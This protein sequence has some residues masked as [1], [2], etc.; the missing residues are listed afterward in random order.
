MQKHGLYPLML[1]PSLHI[2]V[3]G[4]KRLKT[5]L[6]KRVPSDEP[7]G[8]SWELHD[9]TIVGNGPLAGKTLGELVSE[10]GVLLLGDSIN[11]TSG[12]PLLAK[13]IDADSWLSV[14]VHPN[15]EQARE[16]EG[17]PRGKS[18]AWIVIHAEPG[19][20]LVLGCKPGVT[21]EAVADAVGKNLLED[22]LHYSQVRAGD[23]LYIPANTIHA[24]GPGLLI[25]EIQQ[26]SDTTY[27]LYDWGRMG[28]DGK[29]R[30]LHIDKGLQVSDLAQTP[31]VARPK[32]DLIVNG[33]YFMTWRHQLE[34]EPVRV[35]TEGRFQALTCIMGTV[36]V[37]TEG[38]DPIVLAMGESALIPAC[39]S[40]FAMWGMGTVLRSCQKASQVS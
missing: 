29:P 40:A 14:Q 27:R 17:E 34:T 1:Q 20:R 12:F 33:P 26:S 13:F 21:R 9:S 39:L 37:G 28:L 5:V 8:E 6:N 16:L 35:G 22:L 4:G 38:H 31:S 18:E 23:V 24:L 11:A 19:A 25:Y 32:D 15:D 2:K 7:Y 3:W 36:R 30:Q 10:F